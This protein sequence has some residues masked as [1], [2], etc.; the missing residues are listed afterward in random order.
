[1]IRYVGRRFLRAIALLFGASA[2]SFCLFRVAPGDYYDEMRLNPR[3]SQQT[4]EALRKQHGLDLAMPLR[5]IRWLGSVLHGDWGF[6]LAYNSPAAP[7]LQERAANTLVLAG[8]AAFLAWT[9]AVPL[10]LW[11]AAGR[12]WRRLSFTSV[13]TGLLV[14]PDLLV[15]LALTFLIAPSRFLPVGGMTSI[16]FEQMNL[17]GRIRDL[18]SHLVIP[19]TA[20]VLAT[21]PVLLSHT[22]TAMAEALEC[23][24]ITAARANGIP[25]RRLLLRHALPVAA[26]PLITLLGFSIGTLLSSS[27]LVEAIVG[28][29]GLGQLLLQAILQRDLDIVLGAVM[30]SAAFYVS[31]NFIAD[32]LLYAADPRI[33]QKH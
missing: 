28:W 29:P 1:M 12:K 4:V 8:A 26:N 23:P 18:A 7:L 16:D 30:L 20:L 21:L 14:L 27:L 6:S 2:L 9:I 25:K 10:A 22:R 17:W 3:I 24:F 15:I 13:V 33:R 19:G 5:Y 31:A 11:A 32:V